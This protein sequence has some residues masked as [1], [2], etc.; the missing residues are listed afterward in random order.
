MNAP[1]RSDA[2]GR[3]GQL[4]SDLGIR[5]RPALQRKQ[6]YDHLQAVQK[7]M[8]GLLAQDLLLSDQLVLLTKQS[9]FSGKSL[10]QP[11]FREPMSCQLAFVARDRAALRAFKNGARSGDVAGRMFDGHVAR[12]PAAPGIHCLILPYKKRNVPLANRAILT[13]VNYVRHQTLTPRPSDF[14]HA[15][16]GPSPKHHTV[17]QQAPR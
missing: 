15:S 6:A 1:D 5:R 8:I 17:R 11:D 4:R 3:D 10:P 14:R 12:L 7:P 16:P 9:L 13:Q 2:I